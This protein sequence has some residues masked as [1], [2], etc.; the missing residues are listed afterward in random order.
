[1]GGRWGADG[2]REKAPD[3]QEPEKK[4]LGE[5]NPTNI[6]GKKGKW[7]ENREEKVKIKD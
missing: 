7:G 3:W 5:K 4:R 6:R 2:Q 1:M